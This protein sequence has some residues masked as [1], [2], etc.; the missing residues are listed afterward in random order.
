MNKSLIEELLSLA[1]QSDDAALAEE[2]VVATFRPMFDEAFK[3]GNL[4]RA[5][6][7]QYNAVQRKGHVNRLRGEANTFRAAAEALKKA[8]DK[9]S[10]LQDAAEITETISLD[11]GSASFRSGQEHASGKIARRLRAMAAQGQASQELGGDARSSAD[12]R[13]YLSDWTPDHVQ[14]YVARIERRSAERLTALTLVYEHK[15]R[16]PDADDEV[17]AAWDAARAALGIKE[18]V[19]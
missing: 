11:D 4:A 16:D 3:M 15:H 2:V 7:V 8:A 12:A 9:S 6:E 13:R 18:T 14:D 19:R 5:M 10:V 1:R 17:I